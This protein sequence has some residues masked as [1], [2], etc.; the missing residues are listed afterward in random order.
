MKFVIAV[1]ATIVMGSGADAFT[2]GVRRSA[3]VASVS[4]KDKIAGE[5]D[6]PC[7]EECALESYPNMHPGVVTGQALVDLLEDAK[8]RGELSVEV[9]LCRRPL[10]TS[11]P[12]TSFTV[13]V[14]LIMLRAQDMLSLQ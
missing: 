12:Q 13:H 8:K 2:A 10:N 1:F 5:L 9:K 4:V 3:R 6:I 14:F 7:E 11:P